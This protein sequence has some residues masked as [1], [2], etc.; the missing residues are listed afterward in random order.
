MPKPKVLG[1]KTGQ[2]RTPQEVY[3]RNRPQRGVG[4]TTERIIAGATTPSNS[5]PVINYILGGRS[6]DD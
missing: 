2:S 4:P 6:F 3:Q 5:R 1:G